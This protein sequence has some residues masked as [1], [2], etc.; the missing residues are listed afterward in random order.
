MCSCITVIKETWLHK[1]I[2]NTAVEL[3]G[4][5]I[6]RLDCTLDFGKTS[7]AGEHEG[8]AY[9]VTT[10]FSRTLLSILNVLTIKVHIFLP[11]KSNYNYVCNWCV[12]PPYAWVHDSI[13][14]QQNKGFFIVAADF[15]HTNL[16][17]VTPGFYKNMYNK[18]RKG[19]KL[20][21]V[22]TSI[23]E[24]YNASPS[25]NLGLWSPFPDYQGHVLT[26]GPDHCRWARPCKLAHLKV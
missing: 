5:T 13:S 11:S 15:N 19:R 18:T 4:H 24:A 23:P 6:I 12:Y 26:T 1:D 10:A 20:D 25:P 7:V 2:P 9:Y 3:A 14:R 17:T 22:C 8:E 21:Q 16:K